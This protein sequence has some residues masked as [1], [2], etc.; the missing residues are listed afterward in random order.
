MEDLK[1]KR[2]FQFHRYLINSVK[3]M[4]AFPVLDVSKNAVY[5]REVNVVRA[6]A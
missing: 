4:E 6:L 5:Q 2:V 1:A 3:D